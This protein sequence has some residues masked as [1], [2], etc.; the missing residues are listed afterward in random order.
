[1][2]KT[3]VRIGQVVGVMLGI[4]VIG[5]GGIR[6]ASAVGPFINNGDFEAPGTVTGPVIPGWT[7]NTGTKFWI[8]VLAGPHHKVATMDHNSG[9]ESFYQKVSLIKGHKY[10]L[11]FDQGAAAFTTAN[12][13]TLDVYFGTPGHL[14]H[15]KHVS[16][17]GANRNVVLWHTYGY[18]FTASTS[19]PLELLFA[20]APGGISANAAGAG[21]DT[22]FL[23]NVRIREIPEASTVLLF[24]ALMLGGIMMLRKRSYQ[25]TA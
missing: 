19:K 16:L 9:A 8:K 13:N 23:D 4:A 3:N 11:N 15:I 1:M 2:K 5:F 10:V 18:Q 20:N 6:P 14:G 24:G 17:A 21:L 7:L 25:A 12:Q 22:N